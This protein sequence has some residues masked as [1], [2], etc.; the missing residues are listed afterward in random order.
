LNPIRLESFLGIKMAC[1]GIGFYFR[2]YKI[3]M[4]KLW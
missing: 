4:K 1:R 2:S 3:S